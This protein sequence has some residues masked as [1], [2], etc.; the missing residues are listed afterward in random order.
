MGYE[1][2]AIW[3]QVQEYLPQDYRINPNTRPEEDYLPLCGMKIHIDHY[4]V[5]EPKATVVMFHGVGGNGRIL[6][7]IAVFLMKHGFEVICPDLPVYGY[8]EYG[9]KIDY[10]T[11]AQCGSKIVKYY[12]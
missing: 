5:R 12:Q 4:K 11:W 6:S 9:G 2:D 10:E 7:S 3:K 1:N 8:T